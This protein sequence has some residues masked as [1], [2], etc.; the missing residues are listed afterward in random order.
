MCTQPL[1]SS[2]ACDSALFG[3]RWVCMML[4]AHTRTVGLLY[5]TGND[6]TTNHGGNVFIDCKFARYGVD[7][8]RAWLCACV[9]SGC[10]M[11]EFGLN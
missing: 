6:G 11:Y 4:D 8:V 5:F 9:A 10:F 3:Y 7:G 2:H 1:R